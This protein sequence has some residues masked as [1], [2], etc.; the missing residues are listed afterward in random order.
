MHNI[1]RDWPVD[2]CLVILSQIVA[3]MKSDYPRI[4]LDETVFPDGDITLI[5]AQF[6]TT[7]TCTLVAT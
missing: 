2:E 5:S 3:A 6:S 4:I 1:F 7:M